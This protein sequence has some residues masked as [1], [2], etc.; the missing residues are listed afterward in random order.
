MASLEDYGTA[1]KLPR[2]RLRDMPFGR[3]SSVV[4][5]VPEMIF[6]RKTRIKIHSTVVLLQIALN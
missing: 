2:E 4:L 6:E 3:G 1:P 5:M